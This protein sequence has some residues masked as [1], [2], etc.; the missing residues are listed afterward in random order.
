MYGEYNDYVVVEGYDWYQVRGDTNDFSYGCRG[1][2]DW[3]IE[4]E[5]SNIPYVWNKNRDGMLDLIE[6]ANMGLTGI[7][8]ESETGIPIYATIWVEEAYWP[9]FTDPKIG[10]YHKPLLP[11]TYNVIIRANGYKEQQHQV[12][13]SD[14]DPTVLNVEMVRG[15]GRYAEQ[16]T[17]VNF[18]DP[19]SY[20]NNFQN[21]P[22]E[23]ISALGPQDDECASLGVGGTIV[24][25][26][27]EIGKILNGKDDD[28]TVYEGDGSSD[29][30]TVSVADNWNGPWTSLGTGSGD[31]DFDLEDK[32]VDSARFIKIKDDGD[33]SPTET[34]P[35]CDIDAI[36]NL[37]PDEVYVDDDFD[38]STPGWEY[39]HF[40]N[41]QD[42]IDVI[43]GLGTVYVFEGE[44]SAGS[45]ELDFLIDKPISLLTDGETKPIIDGLGDGN[46]LT[47][48]S[49]RVR[50][51]NFIIKNSGIES[52][53]SGIDINSDYNIITDND[54]IENKIGIKLSDSSNN[55]KIYHNNFMN[56]NQN[57]LDTGEF[58]QWDDDY[59]SG[60]NYWHDY[61]GTDSDG[62]GIGDSSYIIPGGSSED[63]YPFMKPYGYPSNPPSTPEIKGNTEG[64][65]GIEYEFTFVSTDEDDDDLFY[66]INWGDGTEEETA[67]FSSGVEVT[68][69]HIWEER[70]T[71]II[72]AKAFDT[73][74][75]ESDWGSLEITIP[76]S[77]YSYNYFIKS[78]LDR[79]PRIF[80]FVKLMLNFRL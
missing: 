11:G 58:N 37:N 12:T 16:V 35:G 39:D 63:R 10:D 26:M 8:T 23:G 54:I 76:R 75:Y 61:T 46:V 72:K 21:N 49:D 3:T 40:D 19:Y 59:P 14:S 62:D 20:P 34:N 50:V 28:F 17:W 69:S 36:E 38:S 51:S 7:V 79:Y 22:T 5:N 71:Y 42:A 70:E 30:Y 2:I 55:N 1:D 25:D 64:K 6:A 78:F 33:G 4:T 48:T 77:K 31:T 18:Y 57:A 47:I 9:C 24:L 52:F 66:K 32:D 43:A 67:V 73:Y 68:A 74:G 56:N 15:G 53:D 45:P 27:G 80:L 60:G 29:G 13:V 41:L 65:P 44:Y